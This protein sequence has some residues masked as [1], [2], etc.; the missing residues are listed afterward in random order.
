MAAT[1]AA[2][3]GF[4]HENNG[5]HE[6]TLFLSKALHSSYRPQQEF[7]SVCQS[8]SVQMFAHLYVYWSIGLSVRLSI[9]SCLSIK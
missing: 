7:F 5:K 8:V 4:F 2:N 9:R 1:L 3:Q 6:K